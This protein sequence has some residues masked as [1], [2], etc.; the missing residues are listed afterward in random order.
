MTLVEG[1]KIAA[2]RIRRE[3][4]GYD[5]TRFAFDDIV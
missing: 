5:A 2:I 3:G 1:Q 4:E